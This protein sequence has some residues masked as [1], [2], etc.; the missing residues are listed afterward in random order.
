VGD[1]DFLYYTG[2]AEIDRKA[3]K[4]EVVTNIEGL[5]WLAVGEE[6]YTSSHHDYNS[7]PA[8]TQH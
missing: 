8:L 4:L 7:Q 5:A 1:I 3:V 6:S 2:Q